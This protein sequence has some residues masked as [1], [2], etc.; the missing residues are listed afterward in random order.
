MPGSGKTTLARFLADDLRV[1]L[2]GR[3]LVRTGLFV[4]WG[5]WKTPSR[6]PTSAESIEAFRDLLLRHLEAGVSVV[7][8]YVLR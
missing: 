5:A 1:P 4:T 3:D 2:I 8:D 6:V 7:A